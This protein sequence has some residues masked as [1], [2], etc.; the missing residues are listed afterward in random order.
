MSKYLVMPIVLNLFDGSVNTTTTLSDDV[1]TYYSNYLIDLVEPELVHD[2]FA[3][4]HPIPKNGGKTIEFRGF[5]AL[6]AV[7]S[8]RKLS[9]GVTPIA[10]QMEMFTIPAEVHQYGGYVVLSDML[11]MTAIDNNVVQATQLI[12]AQAGKT[13]DAVT[14]DTLVSKALIINDGTPK[15]KLTVDLVR[16]AANAL[17]RA[18]APKINGYYVAIVHPDVSY[19]LVTDPEWIAVKNYDSE[20]W[21][22]GEIGRIAGVRFV[23]STRAYTEGAD[24]NTVYTTLFLGANAYAVTEIEGGGLQHIVKQLGYGDDPLNQ[25]A[26]VGW[27]AARAVE[28]LVEEYTYGIETKSDINK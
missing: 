2:Q 20:D 13:L 5:S 17:K 26:S 4:K 21:Y 1:K 18:D 19:D 22:N 11:L 3:M 14:R 16:R 10:Q 25:R 15:D 8:E 24:D 23:E 28:V 9:E 7:P 6:P 27:K 12:A